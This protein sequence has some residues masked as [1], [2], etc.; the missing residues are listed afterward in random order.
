MLREWTG[1]P[2][3]SILGPIDKNGKP[4]MWKWLIARGVLGFT[5]IELM[6]EAYNRLP[7]GDANAASTNVVWTS[8]IAFVFLGEKIHW[9]DLCAIPLNIVG[10]VLLAQPSFLFDNTINYTVEM[11]WGLAFSLAG[12]FAIAS[13]TIVLRRIGKTVHFTVTTLLFS[14]ISIFITGVIVSL[15]TGFNMPCRVREPA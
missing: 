12:A 7:I 11:K 6:Y 9:L 3:S 4:Y 14:I 13:S 2:Q 1:A 5:A 8:L 10:V 15:T